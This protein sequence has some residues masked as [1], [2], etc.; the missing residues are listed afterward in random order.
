MV[1]RLLAYNAGLDFAR[2]LNT[3]LRDDDEYRGIARNLAHLGG[4]IAFAPK[5]ITVTLD[6]P[7][8]PRL[9]RA[10]GMLI[11]EMNT[12]GACIPGDRRP[13]TYLLRGAS[14]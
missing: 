3:Y 5:A 11:E 10:L 8:P 4:S 2:R 13:I 9:A 7:D 1:W 14:T 12:E 6:R